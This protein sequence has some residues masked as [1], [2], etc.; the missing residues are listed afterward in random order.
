M[1][2]GDGKIEYVV[3]SQ[4]LGVKREEGLLKVAFLQ[5]ELA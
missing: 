4:S 1:K 5:T 3:E 2:F